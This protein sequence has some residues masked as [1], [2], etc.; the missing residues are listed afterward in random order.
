VKT[1]W[2]FPGQGAHGPGMLDG[3][4]E[5]CFKSELWTELL[6]RLGEDPR[7][8]ENVDWYSENRHS[9][10]LTVFASLAALEE[11]YKNG[12]KP[13]A[14]AGYSVGALS[15]LYAA[16]ALDISKIL[17]IVDERAQAMNQCLEN[18]PPTGMLACIG[19]SL[20]R[21][22]TVL[23]NLDTKQVWVSNINAPGQITLA[24]TLDVLMIVENALRN[25]QPRKLQ[26]LQTQGAWHC[27]IMNGAREPIHALLEQNLRT[28]TNGPIWMS[29]VSGL[30]LHLNQTKT[31]AED[32]SQQVAETVQ[33][34]K[35]IRCLL[36]QGCERFVEVG[37]G[38][39]LTRFGFFID[40]Q[41]EHIS[42]ESLI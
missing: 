22:T 30:P 5:S 25:L 34:E 21:I 11:L 40:R 19:I 24:G 26:Y 31:V 42:W 10:L 38:S 28:V 9:S 14:V 29:N 8:I 7:K 13:Q 16:G 37:S 2:V 15:A 20:E 3:L 33:W 12:Q 35:T 27:P 32:M 4:P 39:V 18:Q 1:A 23:E 41:V 6:D 17:A 36:A